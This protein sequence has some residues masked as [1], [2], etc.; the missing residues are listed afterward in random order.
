MALV[1]VTLT[2]AAWAADVN[3]EWDPNL[4]TSLAGY[5]IYRA[6]ITGDHTEPWAFV[7]NVPAP[8][9]TYTDTVPDNQNFAYLVTAYD[10]GGQESFVS[11]MT[12]RWKPRP[13]KVNNVRNQ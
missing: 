10:T 12:W 4:E 2:G 6:A 11:N 9:T 7:V 1:L 8:T 13:D 5:K 3:L